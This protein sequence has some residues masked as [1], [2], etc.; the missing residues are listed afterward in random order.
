MAIS[1]QFKNRINELT[2]ETDLARAELKTAMQISSSS[3]NNSLNYGIVPTPKTLVKIADYFQVSLAY[4][5]GY[6]ETNDFVPSE[7]HETFQ[8]RFTELCSEKGLTHYKVANSCG[9]DKSLISRWYSKNYMPSLE[10]A[11][12]LADHF[13]VTLDYLLG[14]SDFK[15]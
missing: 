4:L 2:E 9:F 3:F 5:L 10:I 14:R 7:S 6:D 13:G 11:E 1:T 12:L 8:S 15:N